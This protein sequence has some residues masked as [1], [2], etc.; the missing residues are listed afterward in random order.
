[1]FKTVLA[2][3]AFF[4]LAAFAT[5]AHAQQVTLATGADLT[6]GDYVSSEISNTSNPANAI[7]VVVNYHDFTGCSGQ[8]FKAVL[9]QEVVPDVWVGVA[10]QNEYI[11]NQNIAPVR[12]ILLEPAFVSNPGEDL[13]LDTGE[14]GTDQRISMFDGSPGARLRVAILDN[15]SVCTSAKADIY[16]EL[17]NR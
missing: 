4:A 10:A 1:M 12:T 14:T 16:A 11:I 9:E 8:G 7:R 3:M 13:F 6:I 5:P 15:G 17:F 2:A